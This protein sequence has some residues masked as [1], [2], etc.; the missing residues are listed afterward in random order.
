[1]VTILRKWGVVIGSW[2]LLGVAILLFL[3]M[4][5]GVAL[6]FFASYYHWGREMEWVGFGIFM[7]GEFLLLTFNS[8]IGYLSAYSKSVEEFEEKYYTSSF[9][10]FLRRIPNS[11]G[12]AIGFFLILMIWGII[13]YLAREISLKTGIEWKWFLIGLVGI[14]EFFLYIL[15]G[16]IGEAVSNR[17][18]LGGLKSIFSTFWGVKYLWRGLNIKYF[19]AFI[20]SLLFIG[21]MV[22]I[23]KIA[24]NLW[25]GINQ[26]LAL[27]GLHSLPIFLFGLEG[28]VLIFLIFQLF[29]TPLIT[30]AGVEAYLSTL[31]EGEELP[32][33]QPQPE[34]REGRKWKLSRLKWEKKGTQKEKNS[35]NSGSISSSD[36]VDKNKKTP[37]PSPQKE[38]QPEET[39]STKGKEEKEELYIPPF[40]QVDDFWRMDTRTLSPDGEE[41]RSPDSLSPH[42]EKN[43]EEK[44]VAS[45]PTPTTPIYLDLEDEKEE[46][47]EEGKKKPTSRP[48]DKKEEEENNTSVDQTQR[49]NSPSNDIGAE[50]STTPKIL[51]ENPKPKI[52]S[53]TTKSENLQQEPKTE[54][55]GASQSQLSL[56]QLDEAVEKIV[57]RLGAN[58][59]PDLKARLRE[60]IYEKLKKQGKL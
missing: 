44:K 19:F 56:T 7:L 5:G 59:P 47:E 33:S 51:E 30:L 45:S 29:L 34:E 43:R 3:L 17:T 23:T 38:T 4:G 28:V 35:D 1:V 46:N 25:L 11:L 57:E 50:L 14:G 18:F 31:R 9:F 49:E 60:R 6:I 41:E 13:S 20:T 39:T 12:I 2:K 24:L 55:S 40:L 52:H 10:A 8:W 37:S 21:F 53:H 27:S 22:I 48:P 16:K 26:T 42:E 15:L 54:L 32:T 58:L 36:Q